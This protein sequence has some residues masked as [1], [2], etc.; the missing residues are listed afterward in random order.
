MSVE[1]MKGYIKSIYGDT[2]RGQNVNKMHDYQV[3]AIYTRIINSK[4]RKQNA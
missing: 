2:I 3:L 4:R 1:Q